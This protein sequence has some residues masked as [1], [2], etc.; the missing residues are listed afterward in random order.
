[1]LANAPHGNCPTAVTSAGPA[2]HL[3]AALAA[4]GMSVE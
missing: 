2:V 3:A 1:M 4:A